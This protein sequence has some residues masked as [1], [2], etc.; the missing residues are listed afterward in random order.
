MIKF[1]CGRAPGL[2]KRLKREP[3]EADR[4]EAKVGVMQDLDSHC[5]STWGGVTEG[6]LREGSPCRGPLFPGSLRLPCE[7]GGSAS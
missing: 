3:D 7:G 5:P 4:T 6:T 1:D 2:E